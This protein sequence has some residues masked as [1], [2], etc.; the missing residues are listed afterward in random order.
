[1]SRLS[2][3]ELRYSEVLKFLP[4]RARPACCSRTLKLNIPRGLRKCFEDGPP[5]TFVKATITRLAGGS[6]HEQQP[7]SRIFVVDTKKQPLNPVRPGHARLLLTQGKAAVLKRFPFTIVLKK[8]ID[9]PILEPLRI[10]I[11]PGSK[12]TGIAIMNDAT[13]EVVFAAELTHRGGEIKK[14]LDGRRGVRRGR[15]QRDTRYRKPRFNNR[16]RREGWLPPSTES[17]VCNVVTWV[18]R[19]MRVCP[20]VALSQ[21]LVKFDMQAMENP[22]IQG[23]E[24]QQGTLQGYETREYLLEKWERKCSYCG[25]TDV[26]LQIEHIQCR[27]KGGSNRVSNLCLACEPC[28][29]A[30]G[31][32]DIAV[33]LAKKPDLLKRLLAQAKAP[34]KDAAAVNVTRWALYRRLAML[35]LPVECGTGGRTKFNR[36]SRGLDKQHWLDASCVGASTPETMQIEGIVPLLIKAYGHG[37]RQMCL[38]DALGFPRTKPKQKHFM[39]GFRTGDIVYA[40]IPNHLKNP[41]IHVGRMAAKAS[42]AFTITTKKGTVPDVGKKYCRKIQRSD[43]YGYAQGSTPAGGGHSSPG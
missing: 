2:S 30:K 10:K 43:G 38:M 12:T 3:S 41:G 42:G 32:Q 20:I 16:R 29:L 4:A 35:G 26:P 14:A 19:L 18:K 36:V 17:R 9:S 33:F 13:G 39:H 11:D 22:E 21:E 6:A 5:N 23:T 28:N 15:R 37:C 25:V 34:L 27:A 40:H 1:M 7:M 8:A 31:T 24:Y